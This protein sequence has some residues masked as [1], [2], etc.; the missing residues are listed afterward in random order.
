[1]IV[2]SVCVKKGAF[3]HTLNHYN[4]IKK[5]RGVVMST[6]EIK[7]RKIT[8]SVHP[9]P[10]VSAI[11][12]GMVDDYQTIVRKGQFQTGDLVAYIPEAS[13]LPTPLIEEMGLVGRLAGSEKNRVKAIKLRKVLSQ[14]LCYP[15]RESWVEGQDVAEELGITK[16][17]PVVP[18]HLAGEVNRVKPRGVVTDDRGLFEAAFKFDIENIKK[19]KDMFQEGE[20]V[21]ITEKIHGTFSVLGFMPE[22]MRHED[23]L[24][25]IFF[26]SSKGLAAQGL[27]MKDNEKNASNLY[28]KTMKD[29]K[30]DLMNKLEALAA[31]LLLDFKRSEDEPVW[32]VGE[33]FGNGVQDLR[34]GLEGT[35]YRAFGVKVGD[36]WMHYDEFI[37]TAK[38]YDIPTV[39]ILYQGPFSKELVNNLTDGLTVEGMGCHVREGVVVCATKSEE[40]GGGRK[41][42]KSV[43][44]KYLLR[45][46]EQTEWE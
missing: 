28:V 19:Y 6:F 18:Q 5:I 12:V 16:W 42:L 45:K 46:G 34:Y 3:E 9:D 32:L 25:G 10:E 22:S 44:E 35:S 23:M 20:P 14:G 27:F 33:V 4:Y 21:V 15:A 38:E 30:L 36:R 1:M 17:V 31:N 24:K 2:S 26:C 11:E 13:L 8:V 43:S 37:R 7:V 40:N 41:I 29:P 39:P